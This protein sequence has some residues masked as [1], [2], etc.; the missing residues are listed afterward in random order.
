MDST[1]KDVPISSSSSG[2]Q[3]SAY[4]QQH[5]QTLHASGRL[6]SHV[7][8]RS[9]TSPIS[10][11]VP[12]LPMYNRFDSLILSL[13]DSTKRDDIKYKDLRVFF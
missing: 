10:A 6:M 13:T 9:P 3:S 1:F 2:V 8:G 7:P 4:V 12:S 11:P 5:S